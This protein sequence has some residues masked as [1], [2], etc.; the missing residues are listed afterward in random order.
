[1]QFNILS[2]I[3][4]MARKNKKTNRGGRKPVEPSKR[5]ILVGFYVQQSV[6]DLLGGKDKT[7]E[8]AKEYVEHKA[9][10]EETGRFA[11]HG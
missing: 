4:F 11:M 9:E 10:V 8:I 2:Y 5:M 3:C 6:I 1:M 7:R